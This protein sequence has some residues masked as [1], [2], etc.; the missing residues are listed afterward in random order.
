MVSESTLYRLVDYN[1]FSARNID[2]P[3]KVRYSKRKKKR[4]YK[5]DKCCRILRTYDDY[6]R[7]IELHP[8]FPITQMDTVEGNKGG[9]VILTIHFILAEF[10]LAFL[11]DSNDSQ[12]VI[13]IFERL[14][15]ELRPDIFMYLMPV[16]VCDNGSE[17]SN[18]LALEFD[19]QGNQRTRIFYCDPSA[20]YQKGSLEKNHEFIRMFVPKGQSF[21]AFTQKDIDIMMNHINSY[22][23]GSLANR[24]PYEMFSFYYGEDI[25][26]IF[27][28]ERIPANEVT[29]N[30]SVFGKVGLNGN[31]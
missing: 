27:G 24:C 31:Q 6:K 26:S 12:S 18:P 10:M 13:N 7:F 28:C 17:F 20:P 5:V 14:Y 16:L 22:S 15:L 19:K 11:R 2:L 4:D 3:R 8:D 25:L 21:D 23:R 30:T 1:V 9:K 29:L